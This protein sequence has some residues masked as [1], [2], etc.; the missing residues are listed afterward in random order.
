M[1]IIISFS[2][3]SFR[4]YTLQFWT[5]VYVFAL[6][7]YGFLFNS[8]EI[9]SNYNNLL[10]NYHNWTFDSILKVTFLKI[11]QNMLL[12]DPKTQQNWPDFF[13]HWRHIHKKKRNF[14]K[15]KFAKIIIVKI[16]GLFS[17]IF[18]EFQLCRS[19]NIWKDTY[20]FLFWIYF[21]S[22]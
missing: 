20:G 17:E 18:F 6:S 14:Y 9:D 15:I 8:I 7:F 16:I 12:F 11:S 3:F 5:K 22:S 2:F 19:A 4:V 21:F 13:C 10:R 1:E